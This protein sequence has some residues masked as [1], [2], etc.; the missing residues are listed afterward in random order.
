MDMNNIEQLRG[1]AKSLEIE[2]EKFWGPGK[3]IEEIFG[4][5][6]ESKIRTPT[7]IADYP[8]EISPLAKKCPSN[9]DLVERFEA[10]VAGFEIANGYSELNDPRDQKQRFLDQM[11]QRKLGDQ[12]AQVLDE[13]YIMALE[14]GMPPTSGIG[15]GIDR[16]VMFMT[17]NASIQEVLFFPQMKPER[18]AVEMT[19]DEKTV[20]GVLKDNT[21]IELNL[22]KS[23][24]GLSNKKWDKSI[25]GL[26]KK[27]LSKVNKTDDGL[28]VEVI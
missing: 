15:I 22:L 28:F 19:D 18:K 14:Y 23:L 24:T 9:P 5:C 12:E 2:V 17:N 6:V 21:P 4:E 26:T 10:F 25:K 13:D 27:N 20:F 16:L 8:R 3:I 1:Y 7:F 11:Q